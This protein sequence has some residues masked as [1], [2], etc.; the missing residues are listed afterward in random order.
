MC[1]RV[2]VCACACVAGL[3]LR[4][5]LV[6]THPHPTDA[7]SPESHPVISQHP[8]LPAAIRTL[9]TLESPGTTPLLRTH[10]CDATPGLH[11][12]AVKGPCA[13]RGEGDG[14]WHSL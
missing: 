13:G 4:Q 7:P 14:V 6:G 10:C 1:T 9:V 8:L 5:A 11:L 12:L 3:R 2:R